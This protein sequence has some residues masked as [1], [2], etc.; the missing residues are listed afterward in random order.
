MTLLATLTSAIYA[1]KRT[2][3]LRLNGAT[4]REIWNDHK[5]ARSVY[6]KNVSISLVYCFNILSTY[7]SYLVPITPALL[8]LGLDNA[9]WNGQIFL[10]ILLL[11][12]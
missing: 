7:I 1:M 10:I 5:I 12:V 8:S 6:N 3:Y 2:I 4:H 11:S 9:V